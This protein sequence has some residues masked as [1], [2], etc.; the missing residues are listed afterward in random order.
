MWFLIHSDFFGMRF[1]NHFDSA[2]QRDG[3]PGN[4]NYNFFFVFIIIN[5][6]LFFAH[7]QCVSPLCF[8]ESFARSFCNSDSGFQFAHKSFHRCVLC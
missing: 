3:S 5:N 4:E 2:G 7:A 6:P 1:Q 8:G